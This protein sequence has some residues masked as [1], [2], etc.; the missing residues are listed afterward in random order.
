MDIFSRLFCSLT[1]NAFSV[2]DFFTNISAFGR[3]LLQNQRTKLYTR[4]EQF[5]GKGKEHF[6][7]TTAAHTRKKSIS[8]FQKGLKATL[9]LLSI[10]HREKLFMQPK[11]FSFSVW[12]KF[13][14]FFL[15]LSFVL[16]NIITKQKSWVRPKSFPGKAEF[17]IFHSGLTWN[18]SR[19]FCCVF[20]FGLIG[21]NINLYVSI[22]PKK[23]ELTLIHKS[24]D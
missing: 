14:I 22:E 21:S 10:N 2:W 12:K 8:I 3:S 15:T 16:W 6:C 18:P 20:F 1:Q 13:S 11:S 7:E 9:D 24:Y 5:R 19:R 4:R 17:C 23:K